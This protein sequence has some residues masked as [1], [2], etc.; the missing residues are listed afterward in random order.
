VTGEYSALAGRIRESLKD[1]E[2]VLNRAEE[3]RDKAERSGD[4]GYWDGVALNLHGFY[5][6]I[7]RILE[8]IAQVLERVLPS[9]PEWHRKLL[10]QMSAEVPGVRPPILAHDTRLCLD[11]YRGFRHIVRHVYTFD[12]HPA[13]LQELVAGLRSCSQA[14]NSDLTRFA[15]FLEQS[16]QLEDPPSK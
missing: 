5:A 9:G 11:E 14:A 8:D 16:A 13:R 10:V 6:G 15:D 4:D 7:E 2:Q 1:L 3:L 12:L